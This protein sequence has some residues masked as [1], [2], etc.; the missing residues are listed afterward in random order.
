MTQ[1]VTF[2]INGKDFWHY[3]AKDSHGSSCSIYMVDG[4]S[5]ERKVFQ[6][7]IRAAAGPAALVIREHLHDKFLWGKR[8]E[9]VYDEAISFSIN[10]VTFSRLLHTDR[11]FGRGPQDHSVNDVPVSAK[12]YDVALDASLK[13]VHLLVYESLLSLHP[14][15]QIAPPRSV[16]TGTKLNRRD[17]DGPSL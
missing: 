16:L 6:E 5:A 14:D 7:A 10:E 8:M 3:H 13:K 2:N 9:P 17:D 4:Q 12:E 15:Y 11:K 1:A